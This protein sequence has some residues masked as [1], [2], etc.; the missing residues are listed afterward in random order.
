VVGGTALQNFLA[1]NGTRF[2]ND[3]LSREAEVFT[4]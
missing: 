1:D 2:T 3:P 4:P